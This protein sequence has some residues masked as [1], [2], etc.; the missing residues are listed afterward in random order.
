MGDDAAA[1]LEGY[2]L[3]AEAGKIGGGG[4]SSWAIMRKIPS[5]AGGWN[6]RE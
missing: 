1:G 3:R 4:A 5:S 6:A 2:L